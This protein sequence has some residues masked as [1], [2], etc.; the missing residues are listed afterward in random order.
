MSLKSEFEEAYNEWEDK[1]KKFGAIKENVQIYTKVSNIKEILS[2]FIDKVES[3]PKKSY[4]NVYFGIK[5][6]VDEIASDSIIKMIDQ[7]N[8]ESDIYVKKS[9]ENKKK[10]KKRIKNFKLKFQKLE[11]SNFKKLKKFFQ[12]ET[13]S[14]SK[15]YSS[16]SLNEK[17]VF[18]TIT[19]LSN[20]FSNIC[21]IVCKFIEPLEIDK[22]FFM[23]KPKNNNFIL[24][25]IK[26]LLPNYLSKKIKIQTQK[27]D[28]HKIDPVKN[29]I[30]IFPQGK[31]LPYEIKQAKVRDCYL[32]AVLISLAKLNPKA[33]ENCFVQGLDKIESEENIDIRFFHL[34]K[35]K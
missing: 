12:N 7:L 8:C 32:M 18:N 4:N 1:E 30:K 27:T 20:F 9:R 25:N 2:E 19:N 10:I 26:R 28:R 34:K 33:I 23:E 29:H 17:S 15:N 14:F 16:K 6:L 21:K 13:D 24:K 22:E 35:K 31:P 5:K 3:L 11:K